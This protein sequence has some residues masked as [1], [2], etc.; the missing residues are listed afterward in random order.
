MLPEYRLPHSSVAFFCRHRQ[1][2]QPNRDGSATAESLSP[3][4]LRQS[5]TSLLRLHWLAES[6]IGLASRLLSPELPAA[7]LAAS[8]IPEPFDAR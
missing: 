5:V 4:C 1:S 6:A 8:Q 2:T 7:L 3:L